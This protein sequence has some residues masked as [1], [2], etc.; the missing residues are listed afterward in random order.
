MALNGI[1]TFLTLKTIF[2]VQPLPPPPL[3]KL[4]SLFT[5]KG[6][7]YFIFGADS[8][9]ISNDLKYYFCNLFKG[10]INC[11]FLI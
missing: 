11:Y 8:I 10:F 5:P 7:I 9:L 1:V 4:F 3:F 2:L 6:F